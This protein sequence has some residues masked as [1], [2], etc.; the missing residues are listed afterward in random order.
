MEKR[1]GRD[2]RAI[3]AVAAAVYGG[4]LIVGTYGDAFVSAGITSS[5]V[6]DGIVGI[7][8]EPSSAM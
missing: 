8:W 4:P 6:A 5:A 2:I 1:Y 3:V 7:F